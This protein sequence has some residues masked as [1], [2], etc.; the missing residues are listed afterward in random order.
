[1]EEKKRFFEN[2]ILFGNEAKRSDVKNEMVFQAR[3]VKLPLLQF[4]HMDKT[5]N[6]N[7]H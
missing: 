5:W 7:W 1:M 2:K 4:H 3:R 6:I